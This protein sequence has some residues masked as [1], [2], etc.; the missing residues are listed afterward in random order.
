[1]DSNYRKTRKTHSRGSRASQPLATDVLEGT[2]YFVTDEGV[3]ERSNGIIWESFSGTGSGSISNAI[4]PIL[5]P[6]LDGEDG[7]DGFPGLRGSDGIAGA[8]G[9]AGTQGLRGIPGMDGIDGEPTEPLI[10]AL[11]A[12]STGIP[13]GSNTQVQFNDSN[14]FGGDAG[15]TYNKT[16]DS[17]ILAGL[18][19]I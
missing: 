4:S 13:G 5:I 12:A 10:F 11:Q 17:L 2:L 1:M 7:I 3:I 16:T 8:A 14:V 18:L 9:V 19:D 6:V 15:L